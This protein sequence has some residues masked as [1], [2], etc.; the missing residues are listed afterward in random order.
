MAARRQVITIGAKSERYLGVASAAAGIVGIVAICGSP[1]A[2]WD[3]AAALGD[4]LWS[5][6]L[7]VI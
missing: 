6:A 2:L 1:M 4:A 7:A 3:Y 5:L